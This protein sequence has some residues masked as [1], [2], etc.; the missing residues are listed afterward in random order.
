M[1]NIVLVSVETLEAA[2]EAKMT[3]LRSHQDEESKDRDLIKKTVD[4]LG[5]SLHKMVERV[6]NA[7][8]MKMEDS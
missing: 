5:D 2:L 1:E 4:E 6:K 8:F 3:E 7:V